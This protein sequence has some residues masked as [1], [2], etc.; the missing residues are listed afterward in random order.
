MLSAEKFTQSAKRKIN[1]FLY[2]YWAV[3]S[4]KVT[5]KAMR[6][7]KT[8]ISVRI[9]VR[10]HGQSILKNMHVSTD[11]KRPDKTAQI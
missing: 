11:S 8:E 2:W 5:S 1:P 6:T 3:S 9:Y 10:L 7:A 4:E